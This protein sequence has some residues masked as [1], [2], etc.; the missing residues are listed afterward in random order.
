MTL[1]AE[2][3]FLEVGRQTGP[4]N[5]RTDPRTGIRYY[6]WQGRWLPSVT[7]VRGLAG[8]PRRMHEAAI[9]AV[10]ARAID[11]MPEYMVRLGTGDPAQAE[12]VR[13]ELRAASTEKRDRR[14]AL[15]TAVHAA[16]EGGLALTQVG[17]DIAPRLRQHQAWSRDA[18]VEVLAREFQIWNLTVG[19][20]GTVDLLGRFPDGSVW[21]VDDKTGGDD[22][23]EGLYPEQVLQLVPYLMAEFAGN[24]GIIDPE[25]TD[26]LHQAKGIA[27]LHLLDKGWEFRSLQATSEE[28]AAFRGLLTF[29]LWAAKYPDIDSLTLGKKRGHA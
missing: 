5:S 14:G 9:T 10:V 19:Y 8:V 6:E 1:T 18:G 4:R 26:L 23:D 17:P 7:T 29:A 2:K 28:W 11:K 21:V 16:I 25:L 22:W 12:E 13:R 24:D 15:G 20:A 3:P 27:I